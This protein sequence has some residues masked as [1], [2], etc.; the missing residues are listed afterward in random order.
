VSVFPVSSREEEKISSNL[1]EC[2]ECHA[3]VTIGTD[4]DKVPAPTVHKT[5]YFKNSR[6]LI[7]TLCSNNIS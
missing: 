5:F 4:L 6:P 7:H 1:Q 2:F 3:C